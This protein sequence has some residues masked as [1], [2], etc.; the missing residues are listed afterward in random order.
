MANARRA[1]VIDPDPT[2]AGELDDALKR[3][4]VA[5]VGTCGYGVEASS[6]AEDLK[7]DLI[8]ISVD[9][10]VERALRTAQSVADLLPDA[11]VIAYSDIRDLGL[12]RRVM[13]IGAKDFLPAPV[14]DADLLAAIGSHAPETNPD[15]DARGSVEAPH[16]AGM[17]LAVVG[18]KGGI[19]KSTI[20]TNIAA[21]IARNSEL[22]VLIIDLDSRVGDI[23]V[24]FD[25][26]PTYTLAHVVA[27][28]DQLDRETFRQ[29]LITH[30]SGVS[31]LAAPEHCEEW[32]AVTPAAVAAVV[33]FAARLFDYVVLDAPGTPDEILAAAIAEAQK[34]LVVT[35]LEISSI[36]STAY[37]MESL[38]SGGIASER[39]FLTLNHVN[40]ANAVS[41]T[42]V[43]RVVGRD[44]G[45]E[46]AHD[47]EILDA[48]QMGEP[49]VLASPKSRAAKEFTSL[50][51]A[52]TD[53][54]LTLNSTGRRRSKLGRMFGRAST[55]HN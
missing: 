49:I 34:V 17:V 43:V 18:T 31:I 32:R 26:E 2:S 8:L 50:A 24:L 20:A 33:R 48:S 29:A 11:D 55:A 25:L 42:D 36:K 37:V 12:A 41:A 40:R 10:P 46:L 23:P 52:V 44:V 7:P 28:V 45:F 38:L 5:V 9:R 1:I 47:A 54:A 4:A 14:V 19:G 30:Q 27:S 13:R 51:E 39:L 35:S 21:V 3:Q 6:L 16:A 53:G 15:D 22:S